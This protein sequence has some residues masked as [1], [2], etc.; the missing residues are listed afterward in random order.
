MAYRVFID[1]AREVL[2]AETLSL[3]SD[4]LCPDGKQ[5]PSAAGAL[6]YRLAETY[7]IVCGR[8]LSQRI[9]RAMFRC[10]L[11]ELAEQVG[12]RDMGF[13]ILP[14]PRRVENGL[15]ILANLFGEITDQPVQVTEQEATWT[16]CLT[17]CP[18]IATPE[19]CGDLITG[20]LQEFTTWAGGGR[21]YPVTETDCRSQG[22][23]AYIFVVDKKPLD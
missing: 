18:T 6:L 23:P 19:Q 5:A 13:R 3:M 14:S 21:Y 17:C 4:D 8:G 1:G 10:G 9:G 16:F 11:N 22:A 12:F 7:G 2:G 15:Q 20:I